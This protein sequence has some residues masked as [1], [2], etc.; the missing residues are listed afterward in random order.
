MKTELI[1]WKKPTLLYVL[2]VNGFV[3]F[4]I[5]SNWER[6]KRDYD[7]DLG[8]TYTVLKKIDFDHR[9]HAELIEQIVKWRLRKWVAPGRHEWIE[10][11]IQRVLDCISQTIKEI[12][13]NFTSTNTST[14]KILTD[15]RFI[16]IS[17]IPTYGLNYI[18]PSL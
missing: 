8:S 4:G 2:I 17:P 1:E 11:P 18:P 16:R 9:W 7:R 3:K 6:R 15:R 12:N 10:L 13:L 5:S 14:Q